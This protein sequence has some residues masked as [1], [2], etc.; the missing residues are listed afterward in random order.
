MRFPFAFVGGFLLSMSMPHH[1]SEIAT[2]ADSVLAILGVAFIAIGV[3]C[4]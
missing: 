2:L 1:Q 3:R 4:L